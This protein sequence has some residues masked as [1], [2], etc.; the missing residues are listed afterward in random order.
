MF[1]NSSA[2]EG[3]GLPC[4]EAMAC[5]CALVSTDNGGSRDYAFHDETALVAARGDVEALADHIEL[6]LV[7][8]ARRL[9]LARSG[10]EFIQRYDWDASARRLESFLGDYGADPKRY[11]ETAPGW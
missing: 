8:D 4:I 2:R 1:L 3:F 9:R 11:Q 5:G 10:L 6:L 7:D